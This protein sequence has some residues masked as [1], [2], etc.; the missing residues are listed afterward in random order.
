MGKRTVSQYRTAGLAA[1]VVFAAVGLCFL[2]FPSGVLAFFNTLSDRLG[3]ALSP[4][5]A[6]PFFVA[7]AA[8]YMYVVTFLAFMMYRR[9]E[10]RAYSSTLA[11]AKF[12]SAIISLILFFAA[13][14]FLILL[15]NAVV[16]GLIGSAAAQLA[17]GAG[18]KSS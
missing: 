11:Q 17:R 13:G 14:R 16:D 8:A 18:R 1:A 10:N 7:L 6:P 3:F 12:A 9:P 15:V 4:T 5:S 2:I